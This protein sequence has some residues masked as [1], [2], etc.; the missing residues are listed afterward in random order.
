MI[1]TDK[2]IY[3]HIP[4]TGGTFVTS[5]L[6]QL[7]G[8]KQSA[9][10][11]SGLLARISGY[12]RGYIDTDRK[13]TKHETCSQIPLAFRSKPIVSNTRNPYDLYVSVYEFGW[14]RR[15][16]KE[17][18]P[19]KKYSFTEFIN[20]RNK[21]SEDQELRFDD[22]FLG[23]FSKKF[24]KFFFKPDKQL[25]RIDD[26]Y[27]KNSTY[28]EEMFP[29]HFLRTENL[30]QELYEYL[31]SVGYPAQEIEFIVDVP[32]ILPPQSIRKQNQKWENYYTPELKKWVRMKER[33]LF[34]IFPEYDI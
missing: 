10:G 1:L 25:S 29:V 7:Y 4:K 11:L 14:W 28:L 17:F 13:G 21:L 8:Q 30:N 6:G 9:T 24:I 31:Q 32:K 19:N 2:F 27:L 26:S 23:F 3:I 34:A 5:I 12:L 15:E 20:I 18:N 16:S 33:L 22:L